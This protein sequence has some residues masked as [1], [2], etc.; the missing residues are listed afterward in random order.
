M[1]LSE[2]AHKAKSGKSGAWDDK[3]L[4]LDLISLDM[5]T[6]PWLKGRLKP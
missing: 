4:H 6:A 1:G 3:I 2:N 5:N